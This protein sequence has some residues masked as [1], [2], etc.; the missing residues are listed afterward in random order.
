M[1]I[2][3]ATFFFLLTVNGSCFNYDFDRKPECNDCGDPVYIFD[4]V[5]AG[6]TV[7]EEYDL[8]QF[9]ETPSWAFQYGGFAKDATQFYYLEGSVLKI[10]SGANFALSNEIDLLPYLNAYAAN[11]SLPLDTITLDSKFFF[12]RGNHLFMRAQFQGLQGTLESKHL[13][14]DLNTSVLSNINFTGAPTHF[15]YDPNADLVWAYERDINSTNRTFYEYSYSNTGS[16]Y[17]LFNQY[18]YTGGAYSPIHISTNQV[19]DR[20]L[21]YSVILVDE[22]A[23]FATLTD[24]TPAY[25]I[26]FKY[27]GPTA[28]HIIPDGNYIWTLTDNKILKLLPN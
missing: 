9:I 5:K 26:N 7:M 17:N 27:L 12:I 11:N 18:Q 10:F 23:K 8:S 19:W 28:Y 24:S 20:Y 25:Q 22:M 1:K 4:P 21:N 13:Y 6:V 16:Q 14:Y 2:T 3:I 15:G